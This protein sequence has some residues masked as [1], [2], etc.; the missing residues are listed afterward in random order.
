M[1]RYE[2]LNWRGL[3][4]SKDQF[5]GI[6]DIARDG[7]LEEAAAIA[8]YFAKFGSH[9]PP[10]LEVERKKLQKR[11]EGAPGTWSLGG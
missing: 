8:E 9:L 1:P 5:L 11:A 4:F 6:M 2:D 7:V 3:D 10:E